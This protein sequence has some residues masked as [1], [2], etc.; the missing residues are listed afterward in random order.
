M[1]E[2]AGFRRVTRTAATSA[3]LSRW[4]MRRKLA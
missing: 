3:K 4:L 1:F 2:R